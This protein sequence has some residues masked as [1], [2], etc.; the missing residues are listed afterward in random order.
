MNVTSYYP[1]IMFCRKLLSGSRP[2]RDTSRWNSA[3]PLDRALNHMRSMRIICQ[4]D[5][6]DANTRMCRHDHVHM[7]ESILR[8]E[9]RKLRAIHGDPYSSCAILP[10]VWTQQCE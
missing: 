9:L 8:G 4:S 7:V 3:A 10:L 1:H 5:H 2:L 6:L